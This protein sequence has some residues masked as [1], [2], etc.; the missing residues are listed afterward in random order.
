MLFHERSKIA[1]EALKKQPPVTLE[2]VLE[3]LK[4]MEEWRTDSV[5]RQRPVSDENGTKEEAK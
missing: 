3:Q 1:L 2:I 4:R 5:K